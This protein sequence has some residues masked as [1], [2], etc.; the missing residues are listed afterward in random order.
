MLTSLL[1]GSF[2]LGSVTVVK[3]VFSTLCFMTSMYDEDYTSN[4]LDEYGTNSLI[5]NDIFLY[6]PRKIYLRHK[7]AS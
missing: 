6:E 7:I 3:T 4:T 2:I 5:E 1:L